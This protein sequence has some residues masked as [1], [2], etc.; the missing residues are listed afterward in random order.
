MDETKD[1]AEDLPVIGLLLKAHQFGID[2][3]EAF[4]S[5]G[6]EFLK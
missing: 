6:Q 3:L 1:V 4:V 5:L 2:P